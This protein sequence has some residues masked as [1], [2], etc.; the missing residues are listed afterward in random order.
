MIVVGDEKIDSVA[1]WCLSL[2]AATISDTQKAI[3]QACRSSGGAYATYSCK[4]V[5]WDDVSRSETPGGGLSCWGPNITDTYL[6]SKAGS[7]LFTVRSDNWNEKLGR[8]STDEVAVVAQERPAGGAVGQLRP[9]TLKDFLKRA[10]AFG[11][12]AGLPR[13]CDLSADIL[14]TLCSIRFQTTFRNS[15]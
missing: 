7:R 2:Y 13:G 1:S 8:V 6:T 14:D 5:S 4:T 12:Y 10:P 3:N 15:I 9:V 11:N